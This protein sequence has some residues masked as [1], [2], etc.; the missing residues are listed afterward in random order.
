MLW[1][2]ISRALA[3]ASTRSSLKRQ[4]HVCKSERRLYTLSRWKAQCIGNSGKSRPWTLNASLSSALPPSSLSRSIHPVQTR[5]VFQIDQNG[6]FVVTQQTASPSITCSCEHHQLF[7]VQLLRI[8]DASSY[9]S[10]DHRSRITTGHL[11]CERVA[12]YSPDRWAC[13][14]QSGYG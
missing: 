3:A 10:L 4:R 8:L 14:C 1:K 7:A 11:C 2:S 9:C 6:C 13:F 5:D 12:W